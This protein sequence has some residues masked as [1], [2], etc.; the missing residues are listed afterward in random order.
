MAAS[1]PPARASS[2]RDG[3]PSAAAS[4]SCFPSCTAS[5]APASRSVLSLATASSSPSLGATAVAGP[6]EGFLA[7][8]LAAGQDQFLGP[9]PAGELGGAFGTAPAGDGPEAGLG[10]GNACFGGDDAE[11]AGQGE[12]QAAAECETVDNGD[13]GLAQPCEGIERAVAGG[14]P[15]PPHPCRGQVGE[16][17]DVGS[18]AEDLVPGGADDDQPRGRGGH[19]AGRRRQ[20]LEES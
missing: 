18:D 7:G 11:V 15:V 9:G 20:V 10:Q 14:D 6:G 17:V 12:F 3:A 13:A 4:I 2:T 1:R 19:C 8:E 16:V 5:G